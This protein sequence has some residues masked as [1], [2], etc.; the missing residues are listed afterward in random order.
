MNILV[1]LSYRGFFVTHNCRFDLNLHNSPTIRTFAGRRPLE[2]PLAGQRFNLQAVD[3]AGSHL[4]P[5]GAGLIEKL[6]DANLRNHQF[7]P[8]NPTQFV[9]EQQQNLHDDGELDRAVRKAL[10][11]GPEDGH[12]DARGLRH[13][14]QK[15]ESKEKVSIIHQLQYGSSVVRQFVVRPHAKGQRKA[16]QVRGQD[17]DPDR[18]Q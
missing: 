3:R 13:R 8:I 18:V 17:D 4:L 11:L 16:L 2:I 7:G 12:E 14:R 5:F 6:F 15:R 10:R 1:S 9:F